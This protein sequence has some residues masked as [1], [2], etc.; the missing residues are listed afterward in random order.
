V[1]QTLVIAFFIFSMALVG[2]FY[3]YNRGAMLAACVV[4]YALTAGISGDT[5]VG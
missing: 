1:T 5:H 3:P 2:M 4:L